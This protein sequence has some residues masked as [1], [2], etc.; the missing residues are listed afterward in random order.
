MRRFNFSVSVNDE[1]VTD[2]IID[3]DQS[4]IDIAL[5]PK[6]KN[7]FFDLGD[8]EGV[9]AHI[10][11]II[12]HQKEKLSSYEGFLGIDDKLVKVIEYPY[13]DYKYVASEV[14]R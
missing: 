3:I 12:C 6:W 1:D 10:A 2:G 5:N 4:I 9:A 13:F 11:W 14:L 8:A 7:V